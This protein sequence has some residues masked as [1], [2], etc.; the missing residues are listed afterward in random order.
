MFNTLRAK[1]FLAAI[2]LSFPLS[3]AHTFYSESGFRDVSDYHPNVQATKWM[4]E[5]NFI[6]GDTNAKG[7]LLAIFRPDDPMNR[8]E[9]L[10]TILEVLRPTLLYIDDGKEIS[11]IDHC[12]DYFGA[13]PSDVPRDAWYASYVCAAIEGGIAK[14]YQD[15]TFKPAQPIVFAEAAKMLANSLLGKELHYYDDRSTQ[16]QWYKI[17]IEALEEHDAIPTSIRRLDQFVTRGEMAEMIWRIRTKQKELPQ[18]IYDDLAV[19]SREPLILKKWSSALGG[20]SIKVP[21]L[22]NMS[23]VNNNSASDTSGVIFEGGKP[24]DFLAVSIIPLSGNES[25]S[26]RGWVSYAERMHTEV[27]LYGPL[28][29]ENFKPLIPAKQSGWQRYEFIEYPPGG[30]IALTYYNLFVGRDNAVL[31][32]FENRDG[33]AITI[34]DSFQ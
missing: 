4:R 32:G 15:G 19:T 26:V 6:T 28:S 16:P 2:L 14:G 7:E 21:S 24:G 11:A 12:L 25:D 34:R 17:Y 22:W 18:R 31:L 13:S 10:K 27:P 23:Q 20:F 1:I 30:G 8:V 9:F 33:I 3:I 29:A 5:Q